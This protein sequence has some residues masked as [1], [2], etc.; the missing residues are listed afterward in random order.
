MSSVKFDSRKFTTY[1]D[2]SFY[3]NAVQSSS[4]N[5]KLYLDVL[6]SLSQKS[7]IALSLIHISEILN[8]ADI[9]I[10][11]SVAS[12]IE[13]IDY[14]VVRSA[15]DAIDLE[16]IEFVK[17]G[18]SLSNALLYYKSLYDSF[19]IARK[20]PESL[21]FS[22]IDLVKIVEDRAFVGKDELEKTSLKRDS[23]DT[24]KKIHWDNQGA[25]NMSSYQK[26][27]V[28]EEK[29]DQH[30][31]EIINER[32]IIFAN[33]LKIPRHVFLMQNP[34]LC[35]MYYLWNTNLKYY[36]SRT[37]AKTVSSKKFKRTSQ[38]TL[39]DWAHLVGAAYCEIFTCDSR[40]FQDI[41]EARKSIG[42]SDALFFSNGDHEAFINA[43]QCQIEKM[44]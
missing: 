10:A 8:I 16:I 28:L 25:S 38:T 9:G 31:F 11:K 44:S 22:D 6:G 35:P 19:E 5:R 30:I 24:I 34:K 17:S 36:R 37:Y 15:I 32:G 23:Q 7:N 39:P 14:V 4:S 2:T 42:F 40:T 13:D 1:F 27:R 29:G 20:S 3:R 41:N 12:F 18:N 33:S 43:I 21:N 26:D